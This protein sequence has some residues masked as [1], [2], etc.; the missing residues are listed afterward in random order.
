MTDFPKWFNPHSTPW[1]GNEP[2]KEHVIRRIISRTQI[3][4]GEPVEFK[5]G[6]KYYFDK[7]YGRHD[8][9]DDYY[10]V[11][12]EEEVTPNQDYENQ[13][14]DYN[15]RQARLAT[16]TELKK[17]WD[18]VKE[19]EAKLQRMLQYKKLKAEFEP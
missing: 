5:P 10:L 18:E 1:G 3:F 9:P 6:S 4:D 15:E 14:K 19:A 16:W 13:L 11:E 8:D 17:Q 12:Y 7:E 2:K